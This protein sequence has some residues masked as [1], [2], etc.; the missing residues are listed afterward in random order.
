MNA[1]DLQCIGVRGDE[2]DGEASEKVKFTISTM[3]VK[4]YNLIRFFRLAQGSIG[5]APVSG[6]ITS[7][8]LK[9][10]C[11]DIISTKRLRYLHLC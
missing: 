7:S 1:Y 11:M 5:N 10:F 8:V 4:I 6:P 3:R 2:Y 9:S